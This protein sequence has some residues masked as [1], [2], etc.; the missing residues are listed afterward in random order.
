MKIDRRSF[1][2]LSLGTTVGINFT[3]LPWKLT[4]DISIWTQNWPWTPVPE[5]GEVSHARSVCTLCPGA[6][7]IMVRKVG[8]RVVRINGMPDHPVSKGGICPLGL[9]IPQYLYGP[10]RVKTPLKREGNRGEGKW[11]AV[12]WDEALS[13]VTRQLADLRAADAPQSVAWITGTERG[14]IPNLIDRFLTVYG[15]PNFI[16]PANAHD[17]LEQAVYLTQGQLGTVGYDL[18]HTDVILSFGAGLL[19]GWGSPARMFRLHGDRKSRTLIQIEPRLS[20]TAAKAD[21]WI[22]IIPGT[23]AVLAMGLAHVIIRESLYDVEFI[24]NGA[25]GF[26]SWVDENGQTRKGFREL[27]LENYPP[28]TVAGITGVN[29]KTI[30]DLALGFARADKKVALYGRGQGSLPG[31]IPE[32]LAVQAL[33]ALVGAVYQ[34]GGMTVVSDSDFIRW[35]ELNMDETAAKGRQ[36]QRLDGAGSDA[37]PYSRY[38][39]TRLPEVINA[40]SGDSP[41]KALLVSDANPLH[42]LPDTAATRKA[43][44]RIP[45]IVSFSTFMDETAAYADYVLPHHGPLERLQDVPSPTGFPYSVIGLAKPAVKPLYDTRHI[46]DV[47]IQMAQELGGFIADA[48]PWENYETLLK[49]ILSDHW[50]QLN[51]RGFVEIRQSLPE[52]APYEFNTAST[53]YEFLPPASDSAGQRQTAAWPLLETVSIAGEAQ[54]FPLVL[55]PYDSI[56]VASRQVPNSPFMTK[57]IDATVLKNELVFVEINPQTAGRLGLRQGDTAEISTPVG[58][59]RVGIHLREGIR[60]D[61]I[62]M[63]RGLGRWGLPESWYLNNKGVNIND[64]IGPRPDPFSGLDTAW[65]I[66]ASLTR[67]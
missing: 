10:L 43:F 13:A 9:S 62:A 51:A 60:P 28:A 34:P 39:L 52:L 67:V 40:A 42:T 22:R 50:R 1:I 4:D 14:T 33:N 49:D 26:E 37:F 3:P 38:L 31:G 41:V 18:E 19:D 25:A 11:T 53:K 44:D 64:L 6:C 2:A 46:G 17:T 12:S 20:D 54:R 16:R 32:G 45:L 56:R 15:S 36:Q 27:V 7:G 5:K 8:N 65:G 24:E 23:E 48:F 59:A 61:L 66:R 57:T 63:P 47:V 58:K 21:Q 30:I 55:M 35:P 29:E